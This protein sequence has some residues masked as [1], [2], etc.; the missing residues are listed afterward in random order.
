MVV[1]NDLKF[2]KVS[3][4]QQWPWFSKRKTRKSHAR[5]IRPLL[6]YNRHTTRKRRLSAIV[7]NDSETFTPHEPLKQITYSDM[8]ACFACHNRKTKQ[9]QRNTLRE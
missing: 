6:C 9:E 4:L 3:A 5:C 2:L 8:F 1:Q 7:Q